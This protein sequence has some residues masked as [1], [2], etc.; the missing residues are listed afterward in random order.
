MSFDWNNFLVLAEELAQRGDEAA[1]RTAISRAYYFIFNLA[2]ARAESNRCVF[3]P[4]DRHAQCWR[5]YMGTPDAAC[6]RL[7]NVGERM[8]GR[9]ISADYEAPTKVRLDDE[10]R[11][12][13]DE[14]RQFRTD[15]T[16]LPARFPLP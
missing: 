3:V 7:G 8:K 16:T 6:Q 14:A 10:V 11:R 15:L 9:R 13:L 5:K 2:Y 12:A 4:G 1:K